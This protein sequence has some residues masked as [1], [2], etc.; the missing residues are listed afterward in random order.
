MKVGRLICRRRT[1]EAEAPFSRSIPWL[2]DAGCVV[3]TDI[4]CWDKVD[5]FCEQK[6]D[7]DPERFWYL[8]SFVPKVKVK[9]NAVA[10]ILTWKMCVR[11]FRYHEIIRIRRERRVATIFLDRGGIRVSCAWRIVP[12]RSASS[13]PGQKPNQQ[14]IRMRQ[15]KDSQ[16]I[17]LNICI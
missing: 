14:T 8:V 17:I 7:L 12:I 5:E 13:V 2:S 11:L 6:P 3:A 1:T 15:E 16:K 10:T 9:D 4:D